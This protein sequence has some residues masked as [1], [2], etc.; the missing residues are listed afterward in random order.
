MKQIFLFTLIT[1]LFLTYAAAHYPGG[2][3]SIQFTGEERDRANTAK[4]CDHMLPIE[5]EVIFVINLVRTCPQKFAEKYIRD[6]KGKGYQFKE[7]CDSL[8]RQLKHMEPL[9]PV[10]PEPELQ[11]Q[12]RCLSEE[13]QGG[14]SR[15]GTTCPKKRNGECVAYGDLTALQYV[16]N[17][18]VDYGE[19]NGGLGHRRILLTKR[20][21]YV[22][23]GQ[24]YNKRWGKFVTIAFWAYLR[25]KDNYTYNTSKNFAKLLSEPTKAENTYTYNTKSVEA[26]LSS[27]Q[28]EKK[29]KDDKNKE[30]KVQKPNQQDEKN[31]N[32]VQETENKT[33]EDATKDNDAGN[34]EDDEED[35]TDNDDEDTPLDKLDYDEY[36]NAQYDHPEDDPLFYDK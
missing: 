29:K 26:P 14:H 30:N 32:Q 18:L 17:L 34:K 24:G 28:L 25:W 35:D 10:L 9:P 36:V 13:G 27:A 6:Y 21:V 22:G 2:N 31:N 4:Y 19:N 20:N 8:Y 3:D 5:K 12:M 16:C 1:T 15:E 23:V 33:T 11:A 7:R